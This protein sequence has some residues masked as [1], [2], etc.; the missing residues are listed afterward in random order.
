LVRELRDIPGLLLELDVTITR[1]DRITTGH[2]VGRSAERP[3][4]WNE[5]AAA[6]REDL[7]ATL[8]AWA[9]DVARL[10]GDEP[11]RL[12]AGVAACAEWLADRGATLRLLDQARQLYDEILDA[13]RGVRRVI[14]HPDDATR[15]YAGPCPE[16]VVGQS[17]DVDSS[18]DVSRETVACPGEV[19]AHIPSTPDR[20]ALLRCRTCKARWGTPEWSRVGRRMLARMSELRARA[21]AGST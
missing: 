21:S 11:P 5:R 3:L 14:D 16:G 19:W 9:P 2:G 4:A 18:T 10:S 6:R 13:T 1:A 8:A 7:V 17:A 20:P 15:F 12:G